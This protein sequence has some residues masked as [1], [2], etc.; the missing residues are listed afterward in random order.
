MLIVL[1]RGS[2]LIYFVH[3]S[4]RFQSSLAWQIP[5]FYI[6]QMY[7]IQYKYKCY[8]KSYPLV[9]NPFGS[10]TKVDDEFGVQHESTTTRCCTRCSA[11][12]P[13]RSNGSSVGSRR[14]KPGTNL[15]LEEG[16][17]IP[18]TNWSDLSIEKE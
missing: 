9:M 3:N 7:V 16:V 5:H 1:A 10:F 8:C 6:I 14:W 15:F 13:T 12:Q 4:T 17:N 18:G 11:G 2:D